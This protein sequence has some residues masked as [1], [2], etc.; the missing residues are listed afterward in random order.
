MEMHQLRYVVSVARTGNFSRAAEQCHVS[1]PS[2]SQQIQKLEEELGEKLF[3]RLKR[4]VKLTAVGENFVL[5]ATRILEEAE[6]ASRECRDVQGLVHGTVVIGVLPTIAPYLLPR[7]IAVFAKKH[8]GL[9][10][11]VHE[12]T[13]AQLLKLAAACEI[14]VAI[15]SLPIADERFA[16]ETLLSEELLLAVPTGH[17]LAKQ[18]KVQA[19][20]LESERFILMKEGHCLGDQVLRFCDRREIQP[21]VS[22]RS[23]QIETIKALVR[24]GLGI[25]SFPRWPSRTPR[26]NL[27]PI[28]PSCSRDRPGTFALYG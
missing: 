20:D 19:A 14:D 27:P 7:V 16:K 22:L 11:V 13:T 24:A 28:A 2:L 25:S 21:R 9:E 18:R 4:H 12:E 15:A 1:Q 17:P 10:V 6:N 23:T 8:P 3:D 5:R 26:R